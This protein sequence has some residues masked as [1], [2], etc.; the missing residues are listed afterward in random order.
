M[1]ELKKQALNE[2]QMMDVSG[3]LNYSD[4]SQPIDIAKQPN[5]NSGISPAEALGNIFN[6]IAAS[7][8]HGMQIA[9]ESQQSNIIN[10]SLLPT[11]ISAKDWTG[12]FL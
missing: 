3:G 8:S 4:I 5:R 6:Q 1:D 2:D 11:G 10:S 12:G 7:T 9:V